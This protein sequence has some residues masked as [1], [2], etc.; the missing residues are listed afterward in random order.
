MK[1]Q[2]TCTHLYH[3]EIN[4]INNILDEARKKGVA[5]YKL[6]RYVYKKLNGRIIILNRNEKGTSMPCQHC[7]AVLAKY[8]LNVTYT[9]NGEFITKNAKDIVD[10]K[11][12]SKQR[13]FFNKKEID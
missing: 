3:A 8:E 6:K 9:I 1:N 11:L 13:R 10:C 4:L 7:T 5:S 12:T 2:A